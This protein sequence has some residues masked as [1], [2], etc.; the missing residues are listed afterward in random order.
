M[1]VAVVSAVVGSAV[2]LPPSRAS[3]QQKPPPDYT[4]SCTA[5]GCHDGYTRKKVVH[6]PV[7]MGTCDACH[8]EV[9][10]TDHTFQPAAEGGGALYGLPR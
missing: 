5:V 2:L 7:G 10:K 9:D 3:G 6:G 1:T 8:E 4:G